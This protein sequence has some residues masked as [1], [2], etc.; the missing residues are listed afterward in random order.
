[1]AC[2][3]DVVII[4]AGPAGLMAAKVAGEN[5]LSV[6][7]LERKEH[8]ADIQ[9]SCATMFAIE[10]GYYFGERMY[11]NT[12]KRRFIFPVTGFSLPYDGPYRNFYAW[13][14]YTAD[15]QHVIRLGSYEANRARGTRGR[16]SVTYSKQHV[17]QSL[18]A[19]AERAGVRIFTGTNVVGLQT[20]SSAS[21]VITAEGQSLDATF[22][23]AADGINSRIAQLLGLNRDRT[24]YGTLQG[25]SYYMTGLDLPFP[26][27]INYPML[28]HTTTQYPVMIWIEPSPY[29]EDEFWVYAGGPS[30]PGLDYRAE[31]DRCIADSPFKQWF[32]RPEIRKRQAHVSNIWSPVPAVVRHNVL[33][34]G[35]AAWTVEAECTGSMMSGYKA[36]H[37]VTEAIRDNRPDAEGVQA[38]SAWWRRHFADSMDHSEFLQLLSSAATYLNKLVTETLPCSLNPYNLL[39]SLNAAIM[40]KIGR[41]QHE[42]PDI[43]KMLQHT[44][45]L[46]L[47]EQMKRFTITGFPNA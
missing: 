4:G 23:I 18:L 41:I 2:N 20:G 13:H 28:F 25:V 43:F 40:S 14:L 11:F 39:K 36:A 33:I 9:R 37:A 10:D 15:A 27:A 5:G 1:M 31:L 30:H 35:D 46:S 29:A 44:A 45:N 26:E 47:K 22:V 16:L 34:A 21:R 17:L 24:F 19:D 6:A 12:E 8:I 7:L 32:P 3:Y 38:Y 42:R